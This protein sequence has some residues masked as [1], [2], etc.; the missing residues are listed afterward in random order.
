MIITIMIYNDIYNDIVIF[1][2]FF[3]GFYDIKIFDTIEFS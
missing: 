2:F 3:K 1:F